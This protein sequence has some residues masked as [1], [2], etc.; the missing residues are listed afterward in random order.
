M[1]ADPART[2]CLRLVSPVPVSPTPF[3]Y[4]GPSL[5]VAVDLL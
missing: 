3:E 5:A 1:V 2:E 4:R